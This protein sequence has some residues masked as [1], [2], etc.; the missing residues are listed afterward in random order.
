MAK[1]RDYYLNLFSGNAII[2]LNGAS[3]KNVI[4]EWNTR[5]LLISNNSEIALVQLIQTNASSSTGY[6]IRIKETYADGWDSYNETSAVVYL[7]LGLTTPA[8]PTYH[9]LIGTNLNKITLF[10]TDDTSSNSTTHSGINTNIALGFIF[11]IRTYDN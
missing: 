7:G 6:C 10:L 1:V 11:H 8:I 5:D 3:T 4:M 9:K 2:T